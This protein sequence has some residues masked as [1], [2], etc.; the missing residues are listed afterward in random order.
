MNLHGR[1]L[2]VNRL[3]RE[4]AALTRDEREQAIALARELLEDTAWNGLA[5]GGS[6]PTPSCSARTATVDASS[7]AGASGA[8]CCSE[9]GAR[10]TR[11]GPLR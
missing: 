5:A 6:Q 8:R 11:S 9:T 4:L 3:A 2:L 1:I 7:A 10:P